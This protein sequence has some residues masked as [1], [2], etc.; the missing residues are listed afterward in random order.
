VLNSRGK[1]GGR[2]SSLVVRY[3]IL[4]LHMLLFS[5]RHKC[6]GSPFTS[7]TSYVCFEEVE[8]ILTFCT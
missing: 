6:I 2:E 1:G 4:I 7:D 3:L 5:V 8:V